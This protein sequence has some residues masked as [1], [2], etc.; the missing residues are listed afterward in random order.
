VARNLFEMTP[1]MLVK[2]GAADKWLV[3]PPREGAFELFKSLAALQQQIRQRRSVRRRRTPA[4][5]GPGRLDAAQAHR[6]RELQ[7]GHPGAGC[8]RAGGK[9]CLALHSGRRGQHV[10]AYGA[11]RCLWSPL[12]Y[13]SGHKK[14]SQRLLFCEW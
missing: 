4:K 14:R 10:P 12:R 9:R 1:A 2:D 8:G 13:S 3:D 5:P 6:L 7:P 11:L